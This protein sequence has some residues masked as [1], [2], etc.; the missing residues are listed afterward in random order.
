MQ[1]L[2]TVIFVAIAVLISNPIQA[3]EVYDRV[4]EKEEIRCGYFVEYPFIMKD[5]NTGELSG[6]AYDLAEKIGAALKLDIIWTEEVSFPNIVSDLQSGRYD[7]LCASLWNVAPRNKYI[8]YTNPFIHVPITGYVRPDSPLNSD[9]Y[10]EK[11]VNKQATVAMMDGEGATTIA[12][13]TF[14]QDIKRFDTSQFLD[15]AN[16]L[17]TVKTE[18]AD[19]GFV[20]QSVGQNYLKNNPGSLRNVSPEQ[21]LYKM[22]NAFGIKR[23]SFEF[24]AMINNVLQRLIISGDYDRIVDKYDDGTDSLIRVNK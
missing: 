3:D 2:F 12:L 17:E 23:G 15:I 6:V 16:M 20:I 21:P 7:M 22:P 19:I 24:K 4:I 9:N 11:I 14:G 8:D 10:F 5:P 13:E 18:K 1:K